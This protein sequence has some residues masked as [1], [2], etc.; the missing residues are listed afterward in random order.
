MLK[1]FDF[2]C[3]KCGKEFELMYDDKEDIPVCIECGSKELEHIYSNYKLNYKLLYDPKKD[4]VGWA[5]D[6]YATTQYWSAIDKARANGED[7]IP[8]TEL[9]GESTSFKKP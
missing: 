9:V 2:V 5:Y 8:A 7:V 3:K 4:K 6:G 1:I